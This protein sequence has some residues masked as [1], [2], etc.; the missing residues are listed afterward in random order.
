MGG[1]GTFSAGKNPEFRWKTAGMINGTKI[2][3][4][5]DPKAKAKLPEE[6]KS[7]H[8]YLLLDENGVFKQY[9]EY[10]DRHEIILEIGYHPEPNIDKS[11]QPVIHIHEYPADVHGIIRGGHPDARKLTPEEYEKYRVYFVG[12]NNDR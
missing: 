4:I 11:R 8:S 5:L 6:A 2:L 7:S 1:C 10:D 12:V 3:E 9:R